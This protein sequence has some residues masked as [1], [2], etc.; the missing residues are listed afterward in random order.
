MELFY[1]LII[2]LFLLAAWVGGSHTEMKQTRVLSEAHSVLIIENGKL[3]NE[4]DELRSL[5]YSL[6]SRLEVAL[7]EVSKL[8][9][10]LAAIRN[11]S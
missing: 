11:E 3:K 9:A 5:I 6:Q 4:I 8:S 10:D 2:A 7:L 1:G